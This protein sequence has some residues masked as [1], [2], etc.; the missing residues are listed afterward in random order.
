MLRHAGLPAELL[1]EAV[2]RVNASLQGMLQDERGRWILSAEH[3]DMQSEYA[4]SGVFDGRVHNMVIDRTSIDQSGMRWIIDYKTGSH[5]GGGLDE[6]LDR[7][8]ER[9]R[10]QLQRYAEA[11]G[12]L[13][14]RP[15]RLA[16]YFPLM[17]GWRE[18]EYR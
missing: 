2:E 6:F 11:I 17:Q 12:R 8:Q 16:L 7:E 1:D 4:I 14:D 18:W 5:S 3:D 9:Y 10:G 13:E 15:I